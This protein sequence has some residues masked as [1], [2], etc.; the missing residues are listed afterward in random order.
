MAAHRLLPQAATTVTP[1]APVSSSGAGGAR[2]VTTLRV[3][4]AAGRETTVHVASYDLA[5]TAVRI[6]RLA[7]PAPLQAWC[8]AKG[9]GDALVGG[10]FVRPD[11][12][13]LGELRT[14]GIAR[15]SRAFDAPWSDLRACVYIAGG[16]VT[17]ARRPDLPAAP[18]GDLLQAGPLLVRDGRAVTGDDEGFAAG[19]G[20]FDSDITDGRYPRAALGVARDGR[21]LAVACD[22]RAD[23]EAGLTMAELAETLV[24]LS[25]VT[26]L[27]L[28]GGG[29]TSLVCDGRLRN[30]PREHHGIRLDG[31][32]A[33]STALV[34]I[35]R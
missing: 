19:Q 9:I 3:A 28:D 34:F 22:G 7:R 30:V 18:R 32:R 11:G 33:I 25:A 4:L 17:I 24:A 6:V 26:A 27:N 16:A 21:V 20:Q 13:P 23:D 31:G 12:T 29:S 14:R 10:F 1:P 2:R 35:A 15:P 5:H 8:A